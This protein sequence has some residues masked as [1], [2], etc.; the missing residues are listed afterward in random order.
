L[1]ILVLG[2]RGFI[3]MN[4]V[5]SLV[6]LGYTLVGCD[7]VEHSTHEYSYHKISI[8]SSDFESLFEEPI[9]VCI[10][11][12]G[13]GNV[14]Y[15]TIHPLS[16]FESNT[17]AVIKILDAIRRFRPSCRYIHISSAAVYGNPKR[18]PI[19]EKN[20]LAPISPYGYHKWISEI[21]CKEY[22]HLYNIAISII[23]P[24]SVYGNGLRKQL[25]WDICQKLSSNDSVKLFGTGKET[26]DF[27]HIADLCNLI[28]KIIDT[29]V[30]NYK[31]YNAGTGIETTLE[32]IAQLF[33]KYSMGE[34][35]ISF[36]GE[37][38][39]GDPLNWRADISRASTLGFI[40][41]VAIEDGIEQYI[42]WFQNSKH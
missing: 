5:N 23:R 41:Q 22:H 20:Q 31:I 26:R 18:L 16:D 15:S 7:L 30:N 42:N 35:S 12:A 21:I 33:C 8:Y 1:K 37:K 38:K 2:A 25:L 34:K 27:I 19:H 10:N 6:G 14:S 4:V 39:I 32:K 40:P 3:G 13:S 36:S 29:D 24:F 28:E 9:D 11:A 17:L